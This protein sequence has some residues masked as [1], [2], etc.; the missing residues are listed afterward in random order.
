V[1]G[2]DAAVHF[3]EPSFFVLEVGVYDRDV[4]GGGGE[5][6]FDAGGGE[7]A[8]ADAMEDVEIVLG[9][10]EALDE[11]G[12]AIGRA[13]INDDD[14]VADIMEGVRNFSSRMPMF[15][16]SFSVGITMQRS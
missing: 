5:H 2:G 7:G 13:V 1:L 11:G 6:T 4:G 3:G 8:A 10:G 12:G 15:S 9:M 16:R 14:L